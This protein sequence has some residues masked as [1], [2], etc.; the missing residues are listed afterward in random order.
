LRRTAEYDCCGAGGKDKDRSDV[1]EDVVVDTADTLSDKG[2]RGGNNNGNDYGGKGGNMDNVAG[3]AAV[4][5]VSEEED[6]WS[7]IV[8]APEGK[9]TVGLTLRRTWWWMLLTH[10]PIR[11]GE[12][13]TTTAT[14]MG[15]GGA[16]WT[17]SSKWQLYLMRLMR[18]GVKSTTTST[19]M[20][21]TVIGGVHQHRL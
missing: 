11:A 17:M 15:E 16:R 4:L 12:E 1:E 18:A 10:C 14:M 13:A 8:A 9:T 6:G 2:R 21:R 20:V 5:Y 7:L 3:M 19:M